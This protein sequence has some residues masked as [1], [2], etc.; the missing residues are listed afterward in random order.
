MRCFLV[1]GVSLYA[2]FPCGICAV[3]LVYVSFAVTTGGISHDFSEDT[4][5]AD[6]V[7][8]ALVYAAA[9]ARMVAAHQE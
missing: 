7:Q 4:H 5:E 9:A 3:T 6:I 2:V 1:C 8:G